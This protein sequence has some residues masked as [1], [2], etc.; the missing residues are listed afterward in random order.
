MNPRLRPQRKQR[1]TKRE[2][3]FG[4]LTDRAMT[5]FLAIKN[6]SSLTSV[7]ACRL[8]NRQ[9]YFATRFRQSVGEQA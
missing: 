6:K 3:N 4:G 8:A 5:D 9:I 7:L 1:R 2:E